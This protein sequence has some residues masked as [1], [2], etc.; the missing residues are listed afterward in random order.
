MKYHYD[1]FNQNEFESHR[2]AANMIR[3]GSK[4]LD[5]G[6]ATG[7]FAKELA[8]QNCQTWGADRDKLALAKAEK[9]CTKVCL[10]N[11]D[12][13]I[14]L[15]FPKK[16]FEYVI[17][18]DVIE[19]LAHPEAVLES[20]KPHLKKG[21][22]VIVSVPNVAHASIRWMLMR[23]DFQY[24]DTGILD[25]THLHF[26]TK[27]SFLEILKKSGY[28]VKKCVPTNGMCKVPFLYKIT[29]RLPPAWQYRIASRFPTLFS[30]QFIATALVG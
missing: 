8:K 10:A 2:L 9:Y 23:G 26:F 30:F 21:G 19:H 14:S 15:P 4:V 3:P 29:D 24:T 12:E 18:L 20:V 13:K 25:R 11:L 17:I 6:C 28:K 22:Q 1:Q 16:Y 27:T 5:I 7:Y